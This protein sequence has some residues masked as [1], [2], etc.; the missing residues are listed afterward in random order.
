MQ[1]DVDGLDLKI[2]IQPQISLAGFLS[3]MTFPELLNDQWPEGIIRA[4]M[5]DSNPE[6]VP[7]NTWVCANQSLP[8]VF[9]LLKKNASFFGYSNPE[10]MCSDNANKNQC[11]LTNIAAETKPPL[12]CVIKSGARHSTKCKDQ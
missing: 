1:N 2:S 11:D 6:D 10:N 8:A 4:I 7:A 3:M 9:P 5:G 12:T